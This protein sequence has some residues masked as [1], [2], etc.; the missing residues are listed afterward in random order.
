MSRDGTT[1]NRR[2]DRMGGARCP[3]AHRLRPMNRPSTH[4]ETTARLSAQPRKRTFLASA[5]PDHDER[6]PGA[7]LAV[8]IAADV[9]V[10]RLNRCARHVRR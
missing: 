7:A 6:R 4:L 8:V 10:A 3:R 5:V 9:G 2:D 1:C